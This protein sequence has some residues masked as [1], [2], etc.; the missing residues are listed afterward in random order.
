MD[1]YEARQSLTIV[2]L[3]DYIL[4]AVGYENAI[5]DGSEEGESRWENI[6][7]LKAVAADFP[8]KPLLEFLTDVALVSDVDELSEQVEAVTLLTLHSAKGLEYPVVFVTGL[9]EGLLPHSRSMD[10][11]EEIAEERRLCYVGMTRAQEKLYLTYAFRRGWGRYSGGN[12]SEASRFL[13]DLPDEVL[14]KP[15]RAQKS[16]TV[17]HS[18]WSV[19][20]WER[21]QANP[22]AK[23]NRSS[24]HRSSASPTQDA[25]RAP[26]FKRGQRV[27]HAHY[28]EGIVLESQLDHRDEIVTVIFTGVGIKQLLVGVAPMEPLSEY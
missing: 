24:N 16:Q 5:R 9:E 2:E 11:L 22:T 7:A 26:S 19:P 17:D 4:S 20:S 1:W 3:M 10:S 8:D 15:Q 18:R 23:S 14:N 6:L 28:G 27:R 21:P 13:E 25:Q 12:P